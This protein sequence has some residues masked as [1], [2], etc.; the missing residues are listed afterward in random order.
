MG[1]KIIFLLIFGILPS[2]FAQPSDVTPAAQEAILRGLRWLASKQEPSGAWRADVG[3]KLNHTYRVSNQ[4]KP[5]VGATAIACL[6]FLANGTHP[7]RGQYGENVE[8]AIQFLIDSVHPGNG[9]ITRYGTKMYCHA[10]ATLCLA[11]AYGMSQQPKIANSLQKATHL[12]MECQNRQG[13]WRYEPIALDADISVTVCQIQALRAA[14][15]AGI[16]IPKRH[17]DRALEY[18]QRSATADG[19]FKYQL[20]PT[21]QT[22]TSFAL[23]AA[24]VTALYGTGIYE[25]RSIDKGI[26]FMLRPPYHNPHPPATHYYFYYGHYY[27]IQAMYLKGGSA[28]KQWYPKIRDQLV[29]LQSSE[30]TWEDNVGKPVAT[31]FSLIVLQIPY[32]YLPFFQR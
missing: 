30:G 12:I 32:D 29:Q 5:H 22:R 11:E 31:A 9:Y 14:R 3:Y 6:A 27:A 21:N 15:N 23:T 4:N 18:V 19:S 10:F 13:G 1:K 25:D 7:G 28:W 20:L 16:R 17:I 2:I 8:K 24:G 26:D